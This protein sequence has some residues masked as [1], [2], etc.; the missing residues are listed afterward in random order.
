MNGGNLILNIET[1][2]DVPDPEEI[3]PGDLVQLHST[4]T[5]WRVVEPPGDL[6]PKHDVRQIG[7]CIQ[8]S[9]ALGGNKMFKEVTGYRPCPERDPAWFE[10]PDHESQQT[11]DGFDTEETNA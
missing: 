11:F 3:L 9:P 4:D 10:E 2:R 1:W 7:V 8:G 5:V 6:T